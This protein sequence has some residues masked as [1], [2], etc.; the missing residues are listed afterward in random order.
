MQDPTTITLPSGA[1]VTINDPTGK[2]GKCFRELFG[3]EKTAVAIIT[4]V[5]NRK[6]RSER[7]PSS[8]TRSD[9]R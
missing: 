3:C 9:A 1:R 8:F 6:A 5:T 4:S 2:L 7:R